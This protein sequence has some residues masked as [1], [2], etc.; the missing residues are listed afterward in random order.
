MEM[1]TRAPDVEAWYSENRP[2]G[3][4]ANFKRVRNL[5]SR[6]FNEDFEMVFEPDEFEFRLWWTLKGCVAT[7]EESGS[8]PANQER[9]VRFFRTC[10]QND[11]LDEIRARESQGRHRSCRKY[12][13]WRASR[14]PSTRAEDASLEWKWWLYERALGLLDRDTR[15]F[16]RLRYDEGRNLS[17]TAGR[18]GTSARSLTRRYGGEKLADQFREA[19]QSF[20]RNLPAARLEGLVRRM[21]FRDGLDE[22]EIAR[23]L[24]LPPSLVADLSRG[25]AYRVGGDTGASIPAGPVSS[26]A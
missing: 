2:P 7:F 4:P 5:A 1:Q 6:V 16:V 3:S 21:Y 10:F 14:E 23:L 8:D 24:L 19:I 22:E 20:I 18:M 13:Q 9:F 25:M 15:Q 11:L 12:A 26:S 17:E